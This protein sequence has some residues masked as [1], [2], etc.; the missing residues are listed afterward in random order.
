MDTQLAFPTKNN[1]QLRQKRLHTSHP[2]GFARLSRE[3]MS[4]EFALHGFLGS[5]IFVGNKNLEKNMSLLSRVCKLPILGAIK[6]CK[7][8]AMIE[9]LFH[10]SALFGLVSLIQWPPFLGFVHHPLMQHPISGLNVFEIPNHTVESE[11]G[12]FRSPHLTSL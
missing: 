11:E 9:I 12:M 5:W 4:V 3:T 8:M 1:E 2:S 7:C 6:H 10:S